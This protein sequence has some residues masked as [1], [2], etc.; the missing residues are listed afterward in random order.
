MSY[1]PNPLCPC[2]EYV[3]DPL[4]LTPPSD[5]C[6]TQAFLLGKQTQPIQ[7][8]PGEPVESCVANLAD[9]QIAYWDADSEPNTDDIGGRILADGGGTSIVAG[10]IGNAF[11]FSGAADS[12]MSTADEVGLR[13][14]AT[15]FTIRLWV[16]VPGL[17][18]ADEFV[19]LD[20]ESAAFAGWALRVTR[21][22][23]VRFVALS[24]GAQHIAESI[25]GAIQAGTWHHVV[26][27]YTAAVPTG[28]VYVSAVPS[29]STAMTGS[30]GD[31][32]GGA[33]QLAKDAFLAQ[34]VGQ[35]DEIGIWGFAWTQCEVTADYNMG[36]GRTHPFV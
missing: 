36:A 6:V 31:S 9:D 8:I 23:R 26:V 28:L 17:D 18:I 3:P 35:L 30:V 14:L 16:Y 27:V 32:T 33:L 2:V 1:I 24:G 5:P 22:G 19:L 4:V 12:Y 15:D 20:K 7:C 21:Q 25:E 34:L 11:S 13:L 29:A 10:K